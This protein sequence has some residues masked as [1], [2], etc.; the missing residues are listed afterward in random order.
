MPKLLV[1][2]ILALPLVGAY[3][4]YAS[5]IVVIYQAS[6]VV[7]L[8]HGAMATVPAY[9]FTFLVHAHVPMPL[10][11]LLAL[12]SGALIGVSI[13]RVFVRRLRS[14]GATAQTVG[15]V[16]AFGLLISIT[17]KVAGT[18]SI[19]AAAVFPEGQVHVGASILR[20]GQIGLLA[21][22][23]IAIALLTL[24]FQK[25]WL[26]LAMRGAAA[27]R[28][29]AFIVGVDPDRTSMIAWATGGILAACAGVL[30]AAV[31]SP[32]PYTLSAS[33]LPAYVAALIGGLESLPAA[34]VGS[35]IVGLLIG[36]VPVL[37]DVPVL[38]GVLGQLGGREL[39]LTILAMIVMS[40]RGRRFSESEIRTANAGS[41]P[42]ARGSWQGRKP[43]AVVLVL[44]A[45]SWVFIP[46]IP[47]GVL[48][49]ANQ[50]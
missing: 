26:G 32:N 40:A 39:V 7:N 19:N 46:G 41:A 4:M 43:P 23:L 13:E 50:A 37:A 29:G 47:K 21:V 38:S 10:S 18:G 34:L 24:L 15:T 30:L 6:R 45:L 28:R 44:L 31:I 22:A 20:Y 11:L 49:D 27:N 33:V 36:L 42:S 17:A 14:V 9:L 35:V 3:A 2:L 5:G 8:A 12:A 1:F 25:T 16:A 48:G